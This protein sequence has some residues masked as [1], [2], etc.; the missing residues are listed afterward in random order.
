MALRVLHTA[1][2][3]IGRV[4]RLF[5]GEVWDRLP[6]QRV[7]L[8]RLVKLV[9]QQDPHV[10]L[11]AGDL[12]D[13][14]RPR[15]EAEQLIAEYLPRLSD[16][17]KRILIVI[18]GNHDSRTGLTIYRSWG[19]AYGIILL[20]TTQDTGFYR[21]RH[22]GQGH[23]IDSPEPGLL[24]IRLAHFSE[25]LQVYAFPHLY[26]SQWKDGYQDHEG[27]SHGYDEAWSW[28]PEKYGQS[29]AYQ[30]FVGHSFCVEKGAASS[31]ESPDD[32]S[33]EVFRAGPDHPHGPELF[34]ERFQYIALG[35]LHRPHQVGTYPIYYP[36]SL[37][38]YGP[39]HFRLDRQV[40]LATWHN[41]ETQPAVEKHV[42]ELSRFRYEVLE[43]NN[44]EKVID[45]CNNSSFRRPLWLKWKGSVQL[46]MDTLSSLSKGYYFFYNPEIAARA[47]GEGV[48]QSKEALR[49]LI[50]SG[51]SIRILD[52][53]LRYKNFSDQDIEKAIQ[54]IFTEYADSTRED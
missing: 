3:H 26:S 42:L 6:D 24:N 47:S 39:Q 46:D 9:E 50:M 8:D 36:G 2:W 28:L 25:L 31:S 23:K 54:I 32:E 34:H 18:A 51:D 7:A 48:S 44:I 40:Y 49:A 13:T 38:W 16:L 4:Q 41:P 22:V 21:N 43:T 19:L 45:Y 17:G 15:T 11:I 10:I 5:G 53:F 52:E 14:P 20:G 29:G 37:L 12:Y 30:V 35:H 27:A 33:G 1:D